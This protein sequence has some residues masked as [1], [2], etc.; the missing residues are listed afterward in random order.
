MKTLSV[1]DFKANFNQVITDVRQGK[2]VRVV[3]GRNKES[4]GVFAPEEEKPKTGR[5]IQLGDLQK[6][7]W[8][9]KMKNFEMTDEE[10]LGL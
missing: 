10:L 2:K 6:K 8:T 9:Y 5:S 4:L 7:G 1:A 3:Y